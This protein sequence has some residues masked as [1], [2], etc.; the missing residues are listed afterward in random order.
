MR[1][2]SW[3]V[4]AHHRFE[5]PACRASG[6]PRC[7]HVAGAGQRLNCSTRIQRH[8]LALARENLRVVGRGTRRKFAG[9]RRHLGFREV[10][11]LSVRSVSSGFSRPG[12]VARTIAGTFWTLRECDGSG[13]SE[14]LGIGNTRSVEEGSRG[15]AFRP[16]DLATGKE[17]NYGERTSSW[18]GVLVRHMRFEETV[19]TTDRSSQSDISTR[20]SWS[21]DHGA[22]R[23][24]RTVGGCAISTLPFSPFS[25]GITAENC[26]EV[27][28]YEIHG[29]T[30]FRRG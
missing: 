26:R 12:Q 23:R 24:P 30:R 20:S 3:R 28:G 15:N 7:A 4:R 17:S 10:V 2:T 5:E 16:G 25:G 14:P 29:R 13:C 6:H 9:R 11:F 18:R 22:L 1:V 19:T 27:S 8:S 21:H